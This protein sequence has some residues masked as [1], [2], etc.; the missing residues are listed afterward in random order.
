M[1]FHVLEFSIVKTER[2]S[3]VVVL[4]LSNLFGF[5]SVNSLSGYFLMGL[6][7]CNLNCP[8]LAHT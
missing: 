5:I 8:P 7:V 3:E 6:F 1:G 4:H 2:A